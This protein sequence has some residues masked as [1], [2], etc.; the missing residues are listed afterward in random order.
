MAHGRNGQIVCSDG[1]IVPTD[2]FVG[3]FAS[4]SVLA[5][6]PKI[7]LFQA[8]RKPLPHNETATG[9]TSRSN[10]RID[11]VEADAI[12]SDVDVIE[13]SHHRDVLVGFSTVCDYPSFRDTEEG[14]FFIQYICEAVRADI[15]DMGDVQHYVI[16]KLSGESMPDGFRQVSI[17]KSTLAKR[18]VLPCFKS[19]TSD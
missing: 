9:N 7:A 14:S 15:L 5:G 18:L 17:W 8:C 3:A 6:N 19:G 4:N 11:K 2:S 16:D 10:V 12:C 1:S 13:V